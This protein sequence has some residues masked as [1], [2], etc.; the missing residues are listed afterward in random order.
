MT[1]EKLTS[2]QEILSGNAK[3]LL[4]NKARL[5]RLLTV[6][7]RYGIVKNPQYVERQMQEF[8]ALLEILD[9][10]ILTWDFDGQEEWSYLILTEVNPQENEDTS[11]EEFKKC[12][13]VLMNYKK[14]R[15]RILACQYLFL[16]CGSKYP[17]VFEKFN[18][19]K[20]V[21]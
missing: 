14:V 12:H 10:S 18:L 4:A 9:V 19:E 16:L 17:R 11:T 6:R 7:G 1:Q 5:A 8:L 20:C 3:K 15:T 2:V 13:E 21:V